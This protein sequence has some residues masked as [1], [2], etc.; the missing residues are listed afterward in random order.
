MPFSGPSDPKLPERVKEMSAVK[1]RA[2]VGAFNSAIEDDPEDESKAF[3]IAHAAA[4]RAG[5][6]AMPPDAQRGEKH[7]GMMT[8]PAGGPV[9]VVVV[10]EY[11]PSPPFGG[12]TSFAELDRINE[13]ATR[14]AALQYTFFQF[15]DLVQNALKAEDLTA[16]QKVDRVRA[17]VDELGPRIDA[18]TRDPQIAYKQETK[19]VD[20]EDLRRGDFADRG[21]AEKPTTWKLPLTKTPGGAPDASRIAD[22]ITA[23]GPGGFRGNPVELSDSRTSVIGRIRSAIG[24][25]DDDD[26][27]ERLTGR[28]DNLRGERSWE[29]W[30]EDQGTFH[31][32]KD[33]RGDWRWV[34]IHTNRYEDVSGEIF[35][36]EAHKSFVR[37][38]ED[39]GQRPPLRFWHVPVDLGPSDFIDYNDGFMVSSGT[40]YDD[41]TAQALAGMKDLGCSHGYHYRAADLRDGVYHAYRSFE[42]SVLPRDKAANRLTQFIA[43]EAIPV[44]SEEKRALALD[45]FGPEGVKQID[46]ATSGLQTAAAAAGLRY[47]DLA[48]LTMRGEGTKEDAMD[49]QGTAGAATPVPAAP[50]ETASPTPTAPAPAAPATPAAETPASSAASDAGAGTAPVPDHQ[51]APTPPPTDPTEKAEPDGSP[52][53][54]AAP[55][56][57]VLDAEAAKAFE[58]VAA[59][60]AQTV[61]ATMAASLPGLLADALGPMEERVKALEGSR[62]EQMANAIRPRVGPSYVPQSVVGADR[63][64]MKDEDVPKA[65]TDAVEAAR[66]ATEGQPPA[67]THGPDMYLDAIRRAAV[68]GVMPAMMDAE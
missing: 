60:V 34:A 13:Q 29:P 48:A 19:R 55:S 64:A 49:D 63:T 44:I 45:I 41:R 51:T 21:E 12:A 39:T 67:A 59:L 10:D 1:R 66:K 47:K 20:G 24:R 8:A 27:K 62:D 50:A 54:S 30:T 58:P 31:A 35:S 22:A 61:Q 9:P 53:A 42:I 2:F 14:T 46:E 26:A 32:F 33:E 38:V 5:E 52:D 3:A 17:L 43:G 25:L 4:N 16:G 57:P 36:D 7:D 23:L 68:N 18:V 6:K 65:V 11:E 40:F 28:L 15:G 56:G 37:W